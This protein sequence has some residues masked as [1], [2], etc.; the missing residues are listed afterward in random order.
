[1]LPD[2]GSISTWDF[3]KPPLRGTWNGDWVPQGKGDLS[4]IS[5]MTKAPLACLQHG[6]V[7]DQR[8]L[9]LP[10]WLHGLPPVGGALWPG[11]GTSRCWSCQREGLGK[12]LLAEWDAGRGKTCS[13]SHTMCHQWG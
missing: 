13:W 10:R 9:V 4:L 5:R 7:K 11:W 2:I 6:I 12:G 3:S 8:Y 1:M